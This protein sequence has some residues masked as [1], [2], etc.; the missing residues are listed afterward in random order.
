MHSKR[1]GRRPARAQIVGERLTRRISAAAANKR[2]PLHIRMNINMWS[3]NM[4]TTTTNSDGGDVGA[5]SVDDRTALHRRRCIGPAHDEPPDGEP[6]TVFVSYSRHDSRMAWVLVVALL[7]LNYR[8]VFD[9]LHLHSGDHWRER[10]EAAVDGADIFLLVWSIHAK[11]SAPV[12]WE[13]ELA[14]AR[15]SRA[16]RP[17]RF[18]PIPIE[19]L[20]KAKRPSGLT[21]IHFPD[22]PDGWL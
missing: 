15:M 21:E 14:K 17:M 7:A 20:R 2:N 22:L 18:L 19:A 16:H 1:Q 9:R 12:R 5:H 6:L 3:I 11:R 8:V 13:I 4:S 10:L